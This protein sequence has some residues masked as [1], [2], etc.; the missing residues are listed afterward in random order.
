MVK[1][2]RSKELKLSF[3]IEKNYHIQLTSFCVYFLLN[4]LQFFA[5]SC[6][7]RSSSFPLGCLGL[8]SRNAMLIIDLTCKTLRF[9]CDSFTF[10]MVTS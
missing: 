2:R 8:N 3:Q 9:V 1:V 7:F 5:S 4:S 6:D 10:H